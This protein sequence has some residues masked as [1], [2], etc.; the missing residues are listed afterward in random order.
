MV[1][2]RGVREFEVVEMRRDLSAAWL[3]Y[4]D[5][6]N[7]ASAELGHTRNR[8]LRR[9]PAT[10]TSRK[11]PLHCLDACGR[12]RPRLAVKIAAISRVKPTLKVY[13]LMLFQQASS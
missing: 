13:L 4:I 10:S 1:L 6:L 9:D 5:M 7:V 11:S 3:L 8:C 2:R 12:E